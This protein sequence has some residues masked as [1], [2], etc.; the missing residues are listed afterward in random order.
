MKLLLSWQHAYVGPEFILEHYAKEVLDGGITWE[1]N[2]SITKIFFQV[3]SEFKIKH[4][5]CLISRIADVLVKLKENFKEQPL[6]C[7]NQGFIFEEGDTIENIKTLTRILF[8]S[9][10]FRESMIRDSVRDLKKT[11][12]LFANKQIGEVRRRLEHCIKK[13]TP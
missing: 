8:K 7:V 4:T 6:K 10:S 9:R 12:T 1:Q 2:E 5:L 13:A 3:E 11:R